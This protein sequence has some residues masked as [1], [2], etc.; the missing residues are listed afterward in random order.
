M[1][2][3]VEGWLFLHYCALQDPGEGSTVQSA[4]WF[5]WDCY[6]HV[7]GDSPAPCCAR[8]PPV[9]GGLGLLR[10]ADEAILSSSAPPCLL[11]PSPRLPGHAGLPTP[12]QSWTRDASRSQY[13]AIWGLD[14]DSA[15]SEPTLWFLLQPYETRRESSVGLELPLPWAGCPGGGQAELSGSW[16]GR[17]R[18]QS[19]P[20]GKGLP[21]CSGPPNT[22]GDK[23]QL[24]LGSLVT[25][26]APCSS[27]PP[28]GT[29][30]GSP[31]GTAQGACRLWVEAV[32]E[33]ERCVLVFCL[34]GTTESFRWFD[35]WGCEGSPGSLGLGCWSHGKPVEESEPPAAS[36][37]LT[38]PAAS[39]PREAEVTQY[40]AISALPSE[41]RW[42][43]KRDGATTGTRPCV[44]REWKTVENA[45]KWVPVDLCAP[46]RRGVTGRKETIETLPR[47]QIYP[48]CVGITFQVRSEPDRS[49]A[50]DVSTHCCD[51][52]LW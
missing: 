19:H 51:S 16:A 9:P 13:R 43:N 37:C 26:A 5:S 42:G 12:L 21:P 44:G 11:T 41:W 45:W 50:W 48:K 17:W 46:C 22:M 3:M 6:L 34:E 10:A 30:P 32:R 38:F 33:R 40:H 15:A 8:T 27:P 36:P 25:R 35:L 47:P 18:R 52:Q 29:P 23:H 20:L 2:L 1:F 31:W 49:V 4:I 39:Q 7:P 24:P 28:T 14:N